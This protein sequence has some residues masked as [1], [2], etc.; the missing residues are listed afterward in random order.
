MKPNN[1]LDLIEQIYKFKESI[2]T[3]IDEPSDENLDNLLN[4]STV[5]KN[6]WIKSV[7]SDPSFLSVIPSNLLAHAFKDDFEYAQKDLE[8]Y[9][10]E[11]PS[12]REEYL[13]L[14]DIITNSWGGP[15][16]SDTMAEAEADDF[17]I[18]GKAVFKSALDQSLKEELKFNV[19]TN[20]NN[21]SIQRAYS[22]KGPERLITNEI[23]RSVSPDGMSKILTYSLYLPKGRYG[24]DQIN[25]EELDYHQHSFR[26]IRL[27]TTGGDG[28]QKSI[29][30]RWYFD[31][32]EKNKSRVAWWSDRQ[33]FIDLLEDAN[34]K[35][36]F[37][38]ELDDSR[39]VNTKFTTSS[40]LTEK[41]KHHIMKEFTL[42]EERQELSNGLYHFMISE[43]A[44]PK[45]PS[46]IADTMYL[47]NYYQWKDVV[48]VS[49][50]KITIRSSTND[51]LHKPSEK[52]EDADWVISNDMTS[53]SNQTMRK[54]A[55]FIHTR[56]SI[57]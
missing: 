56:L 5:Y 33:E 17:K 14:Q 57:D 2:K 35:N 25:I 55:K 49:P 52:I 31:K 38:K 53:V 23:A 46:Q 13:K 34:E 45:A 18:T 12:T 6:T 4:F 15:D 47:K 27:S 37:R 44:Y 16:Y 40:E 11:N 51:L 3:F 19:G 30:R 50:E 32:A 24:A 29:N 43:S 41:E 42:P 21:D 39:L 1:N 20:I 28:Q 22:R 48:I 10:E 26:A 7:S 54:F 36:M 8:S 9:L